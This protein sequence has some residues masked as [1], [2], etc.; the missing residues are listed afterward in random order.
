MFSYT[1]RKKKGGREMTGKRGCPAKEA[2]PFFGE[3]LVYKK[4]KMGKRGLGTML[5][6]CSRSEDEAVTKQTLTAL[7]ALHTRAE[8][9]PDLPFLNPKKKIFEAVQPEFQTTDECVATY[10]GAPWTV[11]GKGVCTC[12]SMK[13]ASIK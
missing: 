2:I 11:E 4:K 7:V 9:T 1:G 5:H 12:K 8:G 10:K 13:N 6:I 3:A